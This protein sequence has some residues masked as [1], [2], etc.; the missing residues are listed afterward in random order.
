MIK[1][2][3]KFKNTIQKYNLIGKGDKILLSFSGGPD[4]TA[5]ALLML[6]LKQYIDF[7]FSLF[8]LNHMIRKDAKNEEKTVK[9]FANNTGLDLIV[10]RKNF[11]KEGKK[12]IEERAREY[13]YKILKNTKKKQNFNKIATGH[14]L[15]DQV[16]TFFM[17]LIR[18]GG[19][20]GL[21]GIPV[22]REDI[23]IR[24]LIELSKKELID[25]L[26][27][28]NVPYVVDETNKDISLLRNRVRNL[29]LP[30]LEKK[31]NPSIRNTIKKEIDILKNNQKYLREIAVKVYNECIIN[32]N[33]LDFRK[34]KNKDRAIKRLV[35]RE[36]IKRL[37]GNLRKISFEH[38]E[39]ILN[40]KEGSL[41]YL[42]ELD[43][44]LIEGRLQKL[45]KSKLK[46]YLYIIEEIPNSIY[47]KELDKKYEIY[48]IDSKNKLPEFDD[49]KRAILDLSRVE[50]PIVVRNRKPGDKYEP[51]GMKGKK[52][53]LKDIFIDNKISKYKKNR[54]PVFIDKSKNIIWVKGFN[55]SERFKITEKTKIFLV[56][57]E[58]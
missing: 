31:F 32:G 6:K 50:F 58:I 55:I 29:L 40:L 49:K 41:V 48:K 30:L 8:Y 51:L 42:P 36:F 15:D 43:L 56:I 46:K 39:S 38:I 13:R 28:M 45:R 35:V 20:E 34:L 18:G 4:S 27:K 10:K 25:Y 57:E 19:E 53:K 24:P 7:D 12:N 52:K 11:L 21:S 33:A 16:E 37:K 5:L 23:I 3:L 17:R 22:I 47:I 2:F 54:Q 44:E 26:N 14:T 1:I 9:N